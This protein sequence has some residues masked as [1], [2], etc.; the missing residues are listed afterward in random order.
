MTMVMPGA[1]HLAA[2]AKNALWKLRSPLGRAKGWV[3]QQIRSSRT[4]V[5]GS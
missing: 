4:P 2:T 1:S 5:S 3:K